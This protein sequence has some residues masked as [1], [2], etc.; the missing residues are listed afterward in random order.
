L[1]GSYIKWASV[2]GQTVTAGDTI[3]G[4]SS[5]V[6]FSVWRTTTGGVGTWGTLL[7]VDSS[8]NLN[9]TGSGTCG[10]TLSAT[11]IQIRSLNQNV[12]STLPRAWV[13][14]NGTTGAI[15]SSFNI[16][17]VTR[18]AAGRY[19]VTFTNPFTSTTYAVFGTAASSTTVQGVVSFNPAS[20]AVNSIEVDVQSISGTPALTDFNQVRVSFI[21]V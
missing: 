14:F 10:T 8:G 3:T 20:I 15:T 16:S 4:S 2:G 17:S 13:L 12:S 1:S 18:I 9:L 19:T 21:G 6:P 11:D 7:S 5:A